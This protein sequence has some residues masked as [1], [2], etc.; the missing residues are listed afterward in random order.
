MYY[1]N[2][3]DNNVLKINDKIK[4]DVIDLDYKGDGVSKVN[5][6]F[7]F[8][9]GLLAGEIATIEIVSLRKRFGIGRLIEIHERS[10]DRVSDTSIF[11]SINLSHLS[12][13][14]QLAWQHKVTKATLEK[15]LRKEVNVLDTITNNKVNH[16]R[17]KV[18]FHAIYNPNLKLALYSNDNKELTIVDSFILATEIVNEII[19]SI[20]SSEI[21]IKDKNVLSIQFKTNS[22]N[23]VLVT[24]VSNK[25]GF[26]ELDALVDLFKEFKQVKGITLNLKKHREHILSDESIV[27]YGDNL[28]N[29]G[30]LL[31]NDQSFLQVNTGV[32]NM[33]YRLIK[34][35][36]I[37]ERIVDAYSGVGS[38][39][40]NIYDNNRRITMIDNNIANIKLA[41]II[42]QNNNFKNVE[43]IHA[44][45]ED[46]I[47]KYTPDTI[48]VDPPRKG[49]HDNLINEVINNNVERVIYLSCN[50]QSLARDLKIFSD[51]YNILKAYPIRMF[52]QTNSFETLVIMEKI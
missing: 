27:L 26:N 29:E 45:A 13:E 15:V 8:T 25:K 9:P 46:V 7:I 50:L 18:V 1:I 6:I 32:A 2:N 21:K 16:Y 41:N 43:I 10:I 35:H 14:K 52:P 34:E 3:G 40:F 28:L 36:V 39:G 22:N 19:K 4:V 49:L 48:I 11:G 42:K 17:N 5:D 51:S 20:N 31:A 30:I 23:E 33:V 47:D 44:L 37:G 12:F 24:L 38:I